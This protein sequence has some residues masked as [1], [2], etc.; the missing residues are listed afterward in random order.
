[1]SPPDGRPSLSQLAWLFDKLAQH[2]TE[3]GTFRQL[4]E[5]MGFGADAY[6]LL[7]AAG[8]VEVANALD[9]ASTMDDIATAG[10]LDQV[11]V[12]TFNNEDEDKDDGPN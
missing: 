5:R 8:G 3:G 11:E 4:V 6:E 2:L 9:W 10:G 1:M 7:M 12:L